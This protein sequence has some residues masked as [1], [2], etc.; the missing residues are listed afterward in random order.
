MNQIYIFNVF[1]FVKPVKQFLGTF[2]EHFTT[3][4]ENSLK[5]DQYIE[6]VR[7]LWNSLQYAILEY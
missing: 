4:L 2:C 3:I 5:N 7:A 6:D 1:C